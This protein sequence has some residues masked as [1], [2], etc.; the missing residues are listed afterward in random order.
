M[1]LE[2]LLKEVL[3]EVRQETDGR[4]ID[5]EN[6]NAPGLLRR[7]FHVEIG[8]REPRFQCG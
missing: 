7:P 6:R 2:Q 1:N 5:L 4:N 8:S 3:S